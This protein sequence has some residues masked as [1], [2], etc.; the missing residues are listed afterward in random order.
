M[1][2]PPAAIVAASGFPPKERDLL[3]AT[4]KPRRP[5][6]ARLRKRA[7]LTAERQT[8]QGRSY[9]VVKDPVALKYY[10]FHDEEFALLRSALKDVA[11]Q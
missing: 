1:S 5:A 6:P 4:G 9:W 11:L 7:D 10:R 8:Y 3:P 2:S